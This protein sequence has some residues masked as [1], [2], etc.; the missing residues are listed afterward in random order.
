MLVSGELAAEGGARRNEAPASR[1]PPHALLLGFQQQ[2]KGRSWSFSKELPVREAM[3]F[4]VVIVGAGPAGLAAAIRLKQ[5]DAHLSVVVLEKGSEVGAHI[6]SGAVIDPIGLDQLTPEWRTDPEMP[7][8]TLVSKDRYLIL[9]ATGG[10]ALPKWPMPRLLGNRQF[11]RLA[12]DGRALARQARGIAGRRGISCER[13]ALWRQWEMVGVATGDMDVGRD[14]KPNHTRG[15]ELR[16]KYTLLAEGARGSLT[17]Q[18]AERFRLDEGRDPQN[19]GLA[20]KKAVANRRRTVSA[21]AG[22]A[23]PWLAHGR[24][25]SGGSFLYHYDDN[26]VSVGFVVHLNY[27]N[28]TLSPFDKFQRFKTHPLIVDTF[29]GGRRLAYGARAISSEGWQSVSCFPTRDMGFCVLNTTLRLTPSWRLFWR[30]ISEGG[31]AD[32]RRFRGLKPR[33]PYRGRTCRGA[34]VLAARLLD[35]SRAVNFTLATRVNDGLSVG[36]RTCAIGA[37]PPYRGKWKR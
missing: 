29:A 30:A 25:A 3:E 22:A 11:C 13:G 32:R 15:M 17:K 31:R 26:L 4:D 8:K 37:L 12:G 33:N 23:H 10:I 28:P 16:G 19:S 14:G 18:I 21:W 35:E 34:S 7:L 24:G 5:T 9:T 20:S 27:D 36:S 2:D 1:R 6:P